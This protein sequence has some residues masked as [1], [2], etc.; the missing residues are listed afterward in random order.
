V[1][2]GMLGQQHYV[3]QEDGTEAG[4]LWIH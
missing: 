4:Y 2:L 3:W 1:K